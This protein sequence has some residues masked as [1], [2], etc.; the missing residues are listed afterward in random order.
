MMLNMRG[1]KS[2]FSLNQCLASLLSMNLMMLNMRGLSEFFPR[3]TVLPVCR[4]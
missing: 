3:T 2:V 1:V 4:G